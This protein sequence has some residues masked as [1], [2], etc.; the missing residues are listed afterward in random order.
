MSQNSLNR[1]LFL[2]R[3]G[4]IN[5]DLNYVYLLKDL[6]FVPGIFELLERASEKRLKIICI[7]NQSG[8][9]RGYYSFM[10]L[11]KFN[12][13]INYTLSDYGHPKIDKFY[14]SIASPEQ[15]KINFRE[16]GFTRKPFPGSFLAAKAEFNLD[17]ENSI[18]VCDRWGDMVAATAAGIRNAYLLGQNTQI[19]DEHCKCYTS[20]TCLS[21]IKME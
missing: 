3:D 18:M 1:A 17:L 14:C 4:V 12:N 10:D 8:V 6:S 15:A 13:Y 7:T 21:Q 20:I 11:K 5:E 9:G 19:Q 2:D 16:F